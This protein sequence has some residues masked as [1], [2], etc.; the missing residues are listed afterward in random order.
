MPQIPISARDADAIF[1]S[2]TPNRRSRRRHFAAAMRPRFPRKYSD[3]PRRNERLH[4]PRAGYVVSYLKASRERGVGRRFGEGLCVNNY[5]TGGQQVCIHE[6]GSSNRL[7]RAQKFEKRFLIG[8]LE[9][10]EF[11]GHVLGFTAMAEDGV[12]ERKRSAVVHETRVQTDTPERSGAD[13][14]GGIVVFGDGEIF[15]GDPVHVLAVMLG[16]GLDDAV[17][18]ADIVEEKVTVR[19]K[20]LFTERGGDGESATVDLGTGGSGHKCLDMA[21]VAANFVE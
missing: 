2:K 20:L 9:L 1:T 6:E 8:G 15:P 4:V 3:A 17:A 18:G 5:C 16:H 10:F 11:L 19:M 13:F 21:N 7:E 12:E 14:I